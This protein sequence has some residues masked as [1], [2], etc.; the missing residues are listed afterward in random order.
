MTPPVPA[1]VNGTR[2]LGHTPV[3]GRTAATTTA[4]RP[5]SIR[6]RA[7]G[8]PQLSGCTATVIVMRQGADEWAARRGGF[9]R[10]GVDRGSGATPGCTISAGHGVPRARSLLARESARG[11]QEHRSAAPCRIV[12]SGPAL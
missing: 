6:H 12:A 3:D 1:L 9:G 5:L 8:R 2:N 7:I 10:R 4:G 11:G